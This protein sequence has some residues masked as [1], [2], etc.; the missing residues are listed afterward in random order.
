MGRRQYSND[1]KA[2]VM[3]ALVAGQSIDAVA[4]EYSLPRGTVSGWLSKQLNGETVVTAISEKR[5]RIGE[6]LIEHL[7]LSLETMQKQVR[8]AAK[9]SWLEKQSAENFGVLYGVL[10]A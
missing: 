6:L 4:K 2:A 7:Y 5:E 9:E 10:A 1:A 3:A 8:F